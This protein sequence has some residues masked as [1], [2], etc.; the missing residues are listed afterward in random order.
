M[1]PSHIQQIFEHEF[2]SAGSGA[3]TPV[4]EW[5]AVEHC[6]PDLL[7]YFTDAD[8]EF[9]DRAPDY[10]VLWLVTDRS[11]MRWCERIRLN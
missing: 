11:R 4:F 5:I 3:H 6:Q 1:R 2:A 9:L 8:G 10:P 7:L